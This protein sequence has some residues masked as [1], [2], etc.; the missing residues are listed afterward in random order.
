MSTRER[1]SRSGMW[2]SERE[3]PPLSVAGKGCSGGQVLALAV[4]RPAARGQQPA[5]SKV[6]PSAGSEMGAAASCYA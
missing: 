3:Q 6:Y 4:E 2:L 1:I 5:R